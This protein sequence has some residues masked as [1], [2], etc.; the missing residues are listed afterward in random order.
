MRSLAPSTNPP[1]PATRSRWRPRLRLLRQVF[2]DDARVAALAQR[3]GLVEEADAVLV[4]RRVELAEGVQQGVH[5][6]VVLGRNLC[7]VP[8]IGKRHRV[9]VPPDLPEEAARLAQALDD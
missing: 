2:L 9:G 1:T 8:S 4:Q 7:L 5:L 3:E 6:R